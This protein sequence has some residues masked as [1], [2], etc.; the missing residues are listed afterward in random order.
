VLKEVTKSE[1]AKEDFIQRFI[2]VKLLL[3]KES[4]KWKHSNLCEAKEKNNMPKGHY[5]RNPEQIAKLRA[6][7][8]AFGKARKGWR[9]VKEE[10]PKPVPPSPEPE[11]KET[12]SN[13]P[14]LNTGGRKLTGRSTWYGGGALSS[15]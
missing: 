6:R 9:K 5:K 11:K 8:R 1:E 2:K 14:G 4:S 10:S 7:M 3:K 15:E 13:E 12:P